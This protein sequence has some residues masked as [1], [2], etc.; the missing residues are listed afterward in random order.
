M[1]GGTGIA[2]NSA[3][4]R[5][6]VSNSADN[7]LSVLDGPGIYLVATVQVGSDPGM[8]GINPVT[9]RVYASNRGDDTVQTVVDNFR[10]R[11][12]RHLPL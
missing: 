5:V 11:V 10:R 7:T 9:N 6:F 12:R 2:V 4:G 1:A 8:I 3:T